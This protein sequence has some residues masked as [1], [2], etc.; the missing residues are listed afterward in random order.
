MTYRKNVFVVH[1]WDEA[2]SYARAMDL[3]SAREAGIADYSIPP[4]K[5]VDPSEVEASIRSRIS[6]AS[7]V[8]VLNTPGLH[9]RRV[10]SLE[11]KIAAS[12]E[13]RIVVLQPHGNF[14]Q[15]IPQELDGHIYRVAPWRSDVVGRAIRGAYPYDGRIFDIAEHVERRQIVQYLSAGV[16]AIS[17]VV[18]LREAVSYQELVRDLN[19]KGIRLNLGTTASGEIAKGALVGALL[20]GG[21]AALMTENTESALLAAAAGGAAGAAVQA[22]RTYQ[23][24]LHGTAELRVLALNET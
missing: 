23:A 6:T 3:L 18:L 17:L 11:M 7:S 19:D 9:R 4:W 15:P 13:K 10:S 21:L 22:A 1:S 12:M 14:W 20:A 5:A 2:E 16:G 8:L 24:I